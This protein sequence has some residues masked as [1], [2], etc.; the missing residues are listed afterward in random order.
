MMDPSLVEL[1]R[2]D[3]PLL[4]LED[5]DYDEL[6][7]HGTDR[8]YQQHRRFGVRMCG[9]CRLA[10]RLARRSDRARAKRI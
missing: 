4:P 9:D 3:G 7:E 5:L 8:G 6:I 1:C 10:H 2:W